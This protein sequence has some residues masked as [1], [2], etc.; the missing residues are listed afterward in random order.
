MYSLYIYLKKSNDFIQKIL[1]FIVGTTLTVMVLLIFLQVIFR[2][3]LQLPLSWAEELA[4][5]V[6][7]W[8]IFSGATI[9][10]REN[11]HISVELLTDAIS[12]TTTKKILACI[13]NFF[14]LFFLFIV[15]FYALPIALQLIQFDKVAVSMPSLKMGYIYL[16]I[17]IS[18]IF[19]ILMVLEN[20]LK[21]FISEEGSL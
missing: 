8:L 21:I 20:I 17:P 3:V 19:S 16:I 6:F 5:Y 12:N 13:I 18:S 9:A 4:Q 11:K 7:S 14:V 2:Y 15:V 10:Y 1:S